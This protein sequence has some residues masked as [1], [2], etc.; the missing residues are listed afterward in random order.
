MLQ[1]ILKIFGVILLL[2][3]F[4]G[5]G[6]VYLLHHNRNQIANYLTGQ[7]RQHSDID[8]NIAKTSVGFRQGITFD[9]L[10]VHARSDSGH[11]DLKSP[12]IHIRLKL[13][14]LLQGEIIS[15][16]AELREPEIVWHLTA[17]SD[18]PSAP[19]ESSFFPMEQF[20]AIHTDTLSFILTTWR[21]IVCSDASIEIHPGEHAPLKFSHANLSGR[22]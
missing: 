7:L 8:I 9:M 21:R 22:H 1:R 15:T 14:S 10:G 16:R 4:S 3:A 11:F 6:G 18:A 20:W 13:L 19:E 17:D 12:R 5:A 2:A